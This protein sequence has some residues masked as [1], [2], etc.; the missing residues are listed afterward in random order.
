MTRRE[1]RDAIVTLQRD[2]VEAAEELASVRR[3]VGEL[4]RAQDAERRKRG[5]GTGRFQTAYRERYGH[6]TTDGGGKG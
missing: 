5:R 6:T 2:V 1:M 3:R 4:E